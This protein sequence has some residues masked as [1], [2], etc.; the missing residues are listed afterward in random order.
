MVIDPKRDPVSS[1]GKA[2]SPHLSQASVVGVRL[3]QRLAWLSRLAFGLLIVTIPW[4]QRLVLQAR[5]QPPLYAGFS[6][7]LLYTHDVFLVALLLFWSGS[8]VLRRRRPS[9]GPFFIWWPLLGLTVLS[10]VSAITAVDPLLSAYHAGHLLL[11][12][13]LYLY[14]VNEFRQLHFLATAVAIQVGLQVAVAV[15]QVWR[16][17][18]LGVSW[19]GEPALDLW[20]GSAFVW[21]EGALRSLRAY[22]LADHPNILAASLAF[23]ALLLVAWT[24]TRERQRFL[25]AAL[26]F[27]GAGVALFLTFS[28]PAWM[29]FAAGALVSMALFW[30]TRQVQPLRRWF[31]LL[32]LTMLVILPAVWIYLPYVRLGTSEAVIAARFEERLYQATERAALNRLTNELFIGHAITGTG[33]GT[34][35]VAMQ[36]G[37][38]DFGFDYQPTRVTILNAAAEVGLVGALFYFV[39]LVGP[40]MALVLRHERLALPLLVSLSGILAAVTLF[41][42]LDAYTWSHPSGR[43]WQWLIWGLWAAAYREGKVSS[44]QPKVA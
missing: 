4:R 42:L 9:G 15:A 39:L 33:V 34:L 38:P 40:W 16:Q 31:A 3:G 26:L 24:V 11:L 37:A 18:A 8:L 44:G 32:G 2:I 29:I 36:Q 41:G 19:L 6:D 30:R 10:V 7:L 20:A 14:A 5:P 25:M 27:A 12:M 17:Q 23:G 43:L 35:P 22:G 13:G 1:P 28:R 21:A